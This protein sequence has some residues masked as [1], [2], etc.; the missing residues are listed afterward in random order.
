M[1]DTYLFDKE[2]SANSEKMTFK[3]AHQPVSEELEHAPVCQESD[4]NKTKLDPAQPK[5][6][7]VLVVD[8]DDDIHVVTRLALK[9]FNISESGIELIHAYTAQEARDLLLKH[10]DIAIILLDVVMETPTAGLELA[11]YIRNDLGNNQIRIILRTGQPGYAPENKVIKN[12]AIDNYELK[13]EL[14]S[15]KLFNLL[16]ASARTY[17]AMETLEYRSRQLELK[18]NQRTHQLAKRTR[19]LEEA[20]ATKDKFFSLIAH[21][22]KNPLSSLMMGSQALS[23]GY[24]NYTP[25]EIRQLSGS[26]FQSVSHLHKLLENLL[27]WARAQT[28]SIKYEPETIS[29]Q[30]IVMEMT[31]FF[32]QT[33]ANKQICLKTQVP[34]THEVYADP[35]M[36]RTILRNVVSN[37]IKFSLPNTEIHLKSNLQSKFVEL[38]IKDHGVGIPQKHI[39]ELFRIDTNYHTEGTAKEKGT[40]LGL[41]LCKEFVQLNHGKIHIHSQQDQGTTVYITLPRFKNDD[42]NAATDL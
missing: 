6:W 32:A 23:E 13:T 24:Q 18:V 28:G 7:K 39:H 5:K 10:P 30:F 15:D 1:N 19:E 40:G 21:D 12:Y 4:A 22:L 25:D 42:K 9:R 3:E 17:E 33:V 37:A 36:I 27:E 2:K 34:E 31:M 20:N 38:S 8:D 35:N 14:T 16:L 26:M 29:L 41:V 11:N